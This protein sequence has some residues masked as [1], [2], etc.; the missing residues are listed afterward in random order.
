MWTDGKSGRWRM[1]CAIPAT[2][3]SEL[4]ASCF[5]STGATVCQNRARADLVTSRSRY[6]V[7]R[8]VRRVL[9]GS[10]AVSSLIASA[11]AVTQL[12]QVRPICPVPHADIYMNVSLWHFAQAA[13]QC[14]G[15]PWPHT[16][17]GDV[18]LLQDASVGMSGASGETVRALLIDLAG[19]AAFGALFHREAGAAENCIEQRTQVHGKSDVARGISES[20]NIGA[21]VI[22]CCL[23]IRCSEKRRVQTRFLSPCSCASGRSSL[24]TGTCTSMTRAARCRAS[25][26]RRRLA[27][28]S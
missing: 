9:L 12:I 20:A 1:S 6:L 4:L 28:P 23:W 14:I 3:S 2:S 18:L 5:S 24:G 17:Q 10:A 11:L 13:L 21:D 16:Q 8:P 27:E 22:P 7:P 15:R 25:R 19:F 26:R